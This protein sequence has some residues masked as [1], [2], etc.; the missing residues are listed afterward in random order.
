MAQEQFPN[1]EITKMTIQ[2]IFKKHGI[3]SKTLTRNEPSKK[4]TALLKTMRQHYAAFMI[5][6]INRNK[7]IWN[8]DQCCMKLGMC[9]NKGWS[10]KGKPAI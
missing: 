5:D 2:N 6:Q 7:T 3:T 8:F 10:E 1:F 9:N 4:N